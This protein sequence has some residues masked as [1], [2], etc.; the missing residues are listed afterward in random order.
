MTQAAP[1][2]NR[3]I[4]SDAPKRHNHFSWKAWPLERRQ[5]AVTVYTDIST[6][7]SAGRTLAKNGQTNLSDE[8]H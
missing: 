4:L 5:A 8:L 2:L 7:Q 1:H 6:I 3:I